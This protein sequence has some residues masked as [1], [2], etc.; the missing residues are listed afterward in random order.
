MSLVQI[1]RTRPETILFPNSSYG[2]PNKMKHKSHPSNRKAQTEKYTEPAL[3]K[4]FALQKNVG[5]GAS[6]TQPQTTSW[7]GARSSHRT[8]RFFLH[9]KQKSAAAVLPGSSGGRSFPPRLESF[10][11]WS[12]KREAQANSASV[13]HPQRPHTSGVIVL[14]VWTLKNQ[15]D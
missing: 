11:F 10:A 7:T 2:C 5:G 15:S 12:A 13:F 4:K 14:L 3:D 8:R 1:V 6:T 9:A